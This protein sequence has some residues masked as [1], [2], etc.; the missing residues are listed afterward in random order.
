METSHVFSFKSKYD[1]ARA[2]LDGYIDNEAALK[3][4]AESIAVAVNTPKHAAHLAIKVIEFAGQ[5]RFE[6]SGRFV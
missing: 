1:A 4:M 2:E 5:Y 6:H 3:E